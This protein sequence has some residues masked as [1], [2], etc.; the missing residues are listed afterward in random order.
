MENP[1]Q[2]FIKKFIWDVVD[3][4]IRYLDIVVL[5]F[6]LHYWFDTDFGWK[7]WA[8]VFLISICGHIAEEYRKDN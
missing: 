8:T 2:N 4:S 1:K 5:C 7:Y 6:I 3:L